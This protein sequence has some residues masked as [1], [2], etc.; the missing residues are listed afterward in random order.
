LNDSIFIA[1]I[2]SVESDGASLILPGTTTPTQKHYR[3]LASASFVV[4]DRVLCYRVSGTIIIDD[5]IV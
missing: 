4:G 3:R 5:K 2:A 1:T